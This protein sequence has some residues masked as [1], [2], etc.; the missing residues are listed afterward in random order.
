MTL[1]QEVPPIISTSKYYLINVYHSGT[2]LLAITTGEISPLI[3]IEFL[4]RVFK[5]FEEYFG[6][7]EES[8]IKENFA[9]VYQVPPS[10]PFLPPLPSRCRRF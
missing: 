9:T 10:E 4:H 2:F 3:A 1:L 7:I 6:D 5:I 8:T